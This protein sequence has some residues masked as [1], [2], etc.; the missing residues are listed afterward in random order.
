[1]PTTTYVPCDADRAPLPASYRIEPRY[2]GYRDT[3]TPDMAQELV[4]GRRW[5]LML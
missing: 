2:L 1:M 3:R 5:G 4:H